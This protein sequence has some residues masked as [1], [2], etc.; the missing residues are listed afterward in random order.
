M[1]RILVLLLSVLLLVPIVAT[2]CGDPKA[3]FIACVGSN[4]E[5]IDPAL[6]SAV[7]GAT[8][9]MH[10]FSGLV[11]WAQ[12]EDGSLELVPDCAEEIPEPKIDPETGKATYVFKLKEGLK[13]SDG[14]ALNASDFEYAWK[15]A[16]SAELAA[17]YGYMFDVIDGYYE[18][19]KDGNVLT[20][21]FAL[22]DQDGNYLR[23][24]KTNEIIFEEVPLLGEINVKANDTERTLTV[25]L[26]QDVSYFIELCAFPTYMPVRK[27]I[28]EKYGSKWANKAKSY[29]GNG[30]YK[31]VKWR[32]DS[33]I[34]FEKNPYYHN[35]DKVKLNRIEFALSDNDGSILANYL[36]GTYDFIDSVPNNEI[37]TLK[38]QYADE[39]FMEG[40]LGTYYLSFNVNAEIFDGLSY[41]NAVKF[42]KA[43]SLLLDRNYICETIGQAGQ[44]PANSFVPIGITDADP[45]KEFV[46]F[47]GPEGDGSGYYSVK[48][49]DQESNEALA[50]QLLK[51]A[52]FEY[53]ESTKKFTNVPEIEYIYNTSTAH[54]AIAQYIQQALGKYGITVTLA[55]QEWNVFLNSR[56]KGLYT[57]A[58]NGWLAD[59]NDPISFLDMW[60]TGSGN[61]DAQLGKGNHKSVKAYSYEGQNNLTWADSYDKLIKDIKAQKDINKR[62][63]MLHEAE[64]MLME[65]GCIVPIYYYV[66]VF[67]V[68]KYVKGF[69][70]SPLGYKFFMYA[71]KEAA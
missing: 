48:K 25:V 43:I 15:R 21:R 42:R 13:W 23:D 2:G 8:Y 45:T 40:Q 67:M 37:S 44:Q 32:T 31:M 5:T 46:E 51:E 29:I 7:D 63:E 30:P 62:F 64:T 36:N 50:V 24:P 35:A 69:F 4:P 1:K 16:S 14:K 34:V 3:D 60:T 55:N 52:G 58:R 41:E 53:N 33:K 54:L 18:R 17:D 49:E 12:K 39:F 68:K 71:E 57:L 28:I 70:T 26:T 61:N 56:K 27:D 65:T 20:E 6:N 11:G 38:T 47:N 10:A 59:Y 19:D 9:I 66:D 22:R